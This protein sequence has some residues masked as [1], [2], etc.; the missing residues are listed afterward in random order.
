M[1]WRKRV[2][3][4]YKI[5]QDFDRNKLRRF[6]NELVETNK[7]AKSI[8]TKLEN[9]ILN[10]KNDY[11]KD[12]TLRQFSKWC[13]TKPPYSGTH[14][15]GGQQIAQKISMLLFDKIIDRME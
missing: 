7:K 15:T 2:I 10:F 9:E 11:L 4:M 3:V 13:N 5:K 12:S 8:A 14:K 1:S 6:L